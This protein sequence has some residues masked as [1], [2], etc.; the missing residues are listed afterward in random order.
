MQMM[1]VAGAGMEAKDWVSSS[2]AVLALGATIWLGIWAN[3]KNA[4]AQR[5]QQALAEAQH[6]TNT[7]L[8]EVMAELAKRPDPTGSEK[9]PTVQW[10][11]EHSRKNRWLLRNI[12]AGV[13]TNVTVDKAALG[14]VRVDITPDLPADIGSGESVAIVAIGAW[15]SAVADE[16]RVTWGGDQNVT[17]PLPRWQ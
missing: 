12:G 2:I 7:R 8:V 16:V 9:A 17:V 3:R 10:V 11:A 6:D 5:R 15:G 1:I 4:A 13:A 14:G